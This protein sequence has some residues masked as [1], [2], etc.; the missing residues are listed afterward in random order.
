MKPSFLRALVLSTLA[1]AGLFAADPTGSLEGRIV[2][3]SGAAI[4]NANVE[5]TAIATG[6]HRQTTSAADGGYVFPLLPVGVYLLSVQANGFRH[7]E[8]RGIEIRANVP[9]TAPVSLEIGAATESVTVEA[10][11]ELVDTRSG[12]LRQTI[13]ERKIVDLPLQGRN[14]ATL[15]LLSAG[16]VDLGASNARGL[17]DAFQ[18]TSYPGTQAISSNGA[19]G[20]GVN[21]QL[22][23]GSNVDHYTNVNN[24]FPNPDSLQ[25]FS[26]Q[27]NN[28]NA[29]Y[30]RTYGAIVNIVTK[31]GTNQLHGSAFEYIRNG[32]LNAR[33]FFAATGDKL[34]RN[35]FGGSAGGAIIKDK[36][37]FFGTY[38]GTQTRNIAG[39]NTAF[40]PTAAQRSGDFSALSIQLMDPATSQPIPGNRIPAS[41]IDPF[42]TKL[43]PLIPA[44]TA[45]D[46]FVVFDRPDREHENQFMG[47]VDNNLRNHR[48]YGRYFFSRYP[49]EPVSGAQNLV[50]A[51]AGTVFFN[52][53]VSVS[54]TYTIRP[55]LFNSAIFSFSQTNGT[56]SSSAP[57]GARDAGSNVAQSNPPGLFVTVTGFFAISTGE[58]G[59]F[60]RT[61]FNYSDSAHWVRGLHEFAF[62]GDILNMRTE[63][64]N[65][66]LQNPRFQFQGTSFSGNP[67]AD[68][69]LGTLQQFRQ[70]GG[71]YVQRRG[72]VGALFV[73]DN[74][75]VTP[76]LSLSL[77]LRWE[78]FVPDSDQLGRTEC[79]A[80]GLQSQ[81]FV[82][83]PPGYL[84]AGDTG[85]P[86]GGS[87]SQWK[88]FGPR[89]GFAR[90][91]GGK[92]PM[93]LRGGWGVFYEPPFVESRIAMSNTAPFS[94]QFI[95]NGVP[96]DNPWIGQNNPF[97]SQFAPKIPQ[98]NIG[99]Q[100]PM[101]GISFAPDWHPARVMSWNLTLERQLSKDLLVRAAYV[102]TKGTYL[103]YNTDLNAALY[104]PTATV[105][106]TQQRRPNQNFQTL[107]RDI[108][109]GN[110]IFNSLQLSLEKRL[111]RNF[112]LGANYTF[113]RSIDDV[114]Y[115]TALINVNLINPENAMA[116]RA[117]SD[118]NVP[119]R[120]VLN[121][122]WYLPSPT[123]G[124]R[125]LLGG[126]QTTGI[127]N[128]QS[129]FPLTFLSGDDRSR[130]GVGH[131]SVDLVSTPHYT[132]G[133]RG[134]RIAQWFT[135]GSF[136]PAALGTFGDVG[137]NILQGPGTFNMDLSLLK[138][139]PIKER[140]RLQYRAEFFNALNN[141]E[142]NNPG[143]TLGSASFGRITGARS[144]RILQMALKLYF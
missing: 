23:G 133:P 75:R 143:T 115:L 25:E 132:S 59:T 68:F 48:L 83:A 24:P 45:S 139:F 44:A 51:M 65:T 54:D 39:G 85:C 122:L 27:T 18:S 5:V 138:N 47:R 14:A 102:A 60:K 37:F 108:S 112:S 136:T 100:L 118:F 29:E 126:W 91:L 99:F 3:P 95:L 55:N 12:T 71:Q 123:G 134:Q 26:V 104:S 81:R 82:N 16:T 49:V 70:G 72:T 88:L 86:D 110:S 15:V 144:P 141:T 125:Y 34:K 80:P 92:R 38:Q 103:A 93:T 62:G 74:F 1:A 96:L 30:G 106:N 63:L 107:I 77:G 19:R 124:L 114:S 117:V 46:G 8:Q 7:F 22:D 129:G 33:N 84:Y 69:M 4:A 35:Q 87:K 40:V 79:Y 52:Q 89:F 137:R 50:Q 130:S 98:Q 121:Y 20:D 67:L 42:A 31:S 78:P 43:L 127:W 61:N 13:D 119:H 57:F 41:R 97:P 128:W 9:V 56:V 90:N 28:Y 21:Y 64:E 131:D 140:F 116:Y 94:P 113:S 135:T 6:F 120:F 58:P 111:S 76:R 142:L 105:A 73:Q 10:N 101:I 17:G 109:G 32:A 36:L 11:A 66:F 53:A 2:D